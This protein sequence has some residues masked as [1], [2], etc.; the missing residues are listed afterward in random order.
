MTK[1]AIEE[2]RPLPKA[3]TDAPVLDD[4]T[5]RYYEAFGDLSRARGFTSNGVSL[6]LTFEAVDRYADRFDFYDFDH[7]Y[8]IMSGIDDE[9]LKQESKR[10]S[11]EDRKAKLK[12]K[13]GQHK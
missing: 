1:L 5:E 3:I 2:G 12:A 11:A 13:K 4:L 10:R 8:R 6:P 7:F 9:Y